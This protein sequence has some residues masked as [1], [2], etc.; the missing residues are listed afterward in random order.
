MQNLKRWMLKTRV[1]KTL[2]KGLGLTCLVIAT[3]IADSEKL[4]LPTALV[5]VGALLIIF[6]GDDY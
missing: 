2:L 3:A 1:V 6:S 4:L 5:I